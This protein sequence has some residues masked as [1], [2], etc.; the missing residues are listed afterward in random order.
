MSVNRMWKLERDTLMPNSYKT[1]GCSNLELVVVFF[2]TL[3]VHVFTNV[4]STRYTYMYC[5][6]MLMQFKRNRRPDP[7][8]VVPVN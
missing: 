8:P 2:D 5:F 3:T 6:R 1:F 7:F 4:Y